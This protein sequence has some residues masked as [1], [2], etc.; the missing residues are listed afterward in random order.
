MAQ[1][2]WPITD[3]LWDQTEESYLK[4]ASDDQKN[5]YSRMSQKE[6]V[7]ALIGFVSAQPI[8]RGMKS[9]R[10][11]LIEKLSAKAASRE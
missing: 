10:K 2:Y 9:W 8:R 6:K 3:K 7:Q 5:E 11:F 4:T 1:E